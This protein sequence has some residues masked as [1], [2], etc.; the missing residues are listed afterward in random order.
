MRQFVAF[1]LAFVFLTAAGTQSVLARR[2]RKRK[3]RCPSWRTS[4]RSSSSSRTRTP[5]SA[6]R[7]RRR[8]A[9]G[10]ARAKDVKDAIVPLTEVLRKDDEVSVRRTRRGRSVQDRPGAQAGP[11]AVD[12]SLKERQ[13]PPGKDRRGHRARGSGRRGQGRQL[14]ALQAARDEVKDAGKKDKQKKALGKAT[15]AAIAAI[16]GSKKK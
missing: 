2:R 9:R 3:S 16:T 14:S 1:G 15:G 11:G 12:R 13:G 4:P 10:Q 5:R 6:P 8:G 7:R